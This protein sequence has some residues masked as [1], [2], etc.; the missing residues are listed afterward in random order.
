LQGGAIAAFLTATMIAL[1]TGMTC[2]FILHQP[3]VPEELMRMR[4]SR[5]KVGGMRK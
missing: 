3:E 1:D 2:R 5:K 4:E